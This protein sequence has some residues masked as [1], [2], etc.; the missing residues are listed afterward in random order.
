MLKWREGSEYPDVESLSRAYRG[1]IKENIKTLAKYLAATAVFVSAIYFASREWLVLAG[2]L[3]FVLILI[4]YMAI[5][6]S[7]Y[8]KTAAKIRTCN[9]TWTVGKLQ[10]KFKRDW[11]DI[12]SGPA[13][14]IKYGDEWHAADANSYNDCGVGSLVVLLDLDGQVTC[15]PIPKGEGW[16]RLKAE[17]RA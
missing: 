12:T 16:K 15:T 17:A 5:K 9:F 13:Y 7:G 11:F 10:N 1:K 14:Q 8:N 4:C 3:V 2:G 6:Q